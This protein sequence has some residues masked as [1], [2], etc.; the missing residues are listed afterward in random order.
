MHLKKSKEGIA[1][2]AEFYLAPITAAKFLG[3]S[4]WHNVP[5][6][7]EPTMHRGRI[8]YWPYTQLRVFEK[9]YQLLLEEGIFDDET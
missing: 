9:E 7:S 2:L 1:A 4:P 8:L 3:R 6:P 5:V